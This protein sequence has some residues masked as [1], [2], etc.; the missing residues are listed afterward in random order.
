MRAI[1]K[2]NSCPICKDKSNQIMIAE[3]YKKF[4]DYKGDILPDSNF[5]DVFHCGKN[6]KK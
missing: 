5:G 3:E 1:N 6:A 4:G 2:N